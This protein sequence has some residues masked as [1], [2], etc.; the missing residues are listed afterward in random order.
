MNNDYVIKS[1]KNCLF[2]DTTAKHVSSL[3]SPEKNTNPFHR[4]EVEARAYLAPLTPKK[5]TLIIRAT[6]KSIAT[7]IAANNRTNTITLSSNIDRS[8]LAGRGARSYQHLVAADPTIDEAFTIAGDNPSPSP[9]A[10]IETWK[11]LVNVDRGR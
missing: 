7:T 3:L 9:C 10:D 4:I 6:R 8:V 11:G 2:S 1:H 5:I